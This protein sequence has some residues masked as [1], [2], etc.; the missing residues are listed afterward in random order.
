MMMSISETI[1][2]Y[3]KI[4]T[5]QALYDLAKRGVRLQKT[6]VTTTIVH[7]KMF[8]FFD[9]HFIEKYMRWKKSNPGKRVTW[10]ILEELE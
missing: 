2:L 7:G 8:Y 10:K 3:G 1:K 4:V 5:R 6:W 9:S